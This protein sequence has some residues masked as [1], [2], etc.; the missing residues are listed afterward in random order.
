MK[1]P[2]PTI[3]TVP[4]SKLQ[5]WAKNPRKNHAVDKIA[6]SI[7]AFGYVSPIVVQK[8]TYRILAGHGRLEA[9]KKR[10]VEQVPVV[11]VGLSD[12]QADLYTVGDNKLAELADWDED[13][14][15]SLMASFS[16]RGLDSVL[17]G[18]ESSEIQDLMEVGV[19]E[20]E[21]PAPEAPKDS[22]SKRGDIWELGQHRIMCGDMQSAEDDERLTSG[23]IGGIVTDPPYGVGY[24][25]ESWDDTD[26]AKNDALFAR[27]NRAQLPLVYFCG[28][29]NLLRE[30]Q[31]GPC[32]I[33]I[34]HKP[35]SMTHSGIGNGR[36][37]WEPIIVRNL[38]KGSYLPSDLL[39]LNTDR[40][41]GLRDEH[42]CPKP[43][44]LIRELMKSLIPEGN[45]YEPF[46]G[47]GTAIIAAEQLDRRCFAMEIEPRYVDVAVK[48]WQN[49]TG[50]KA[51][52]LTRP[53]VEIG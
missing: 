39:S 53:Q 50:K 43:V 42:S 41:P 28:S 21:P 46:S 20:E 31:R 27:I 5:P 26:R 12:N 19:D 25:Y 33:V 47:S 17:T 7:E 6:A 10:G 44:K 1:L 16:D 38:A 9:L 22:V 48:R 34:W 24:E 23:D 2:P 3:E 40:I 18:F 36:H 15:S 8:D 29:V 13:G 30:M 51:K 35:W 4:L 14:L 52:N 37:H 32:K 45:I 49:F 11:V